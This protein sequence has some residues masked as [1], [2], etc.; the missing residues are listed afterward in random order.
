[1]KCWLQKIPEESLFQWVA[2]WPGPWQWSDRL[3]TWGQWWERWVHVQGKWQ[4]L[5]AFASDGYDDPEV[6]RGPIL[7]F[8]KWRFVAA[9]EE[10]W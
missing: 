3:Q 5:P 7:I 2:W 1:M 8:G 6:H 4:Q 9:G 10:P